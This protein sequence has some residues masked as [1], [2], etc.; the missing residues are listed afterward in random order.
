VP[1]GTHHRVQ[2]LLL[3]DAGG[4]LCL[5]CDG[6][7]EWRL[8][9]PASAR[10]LVG[11]RVTATGTRDDFNLLAVLSIEGQGPRREQFVA[12]W[13]FAAGVATS[14]LALAMASILLG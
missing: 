3:R 10:S 8:E 6:G 1:R 4:G 12:S 11:H 5:R 2:G 9:A 7:G 14:L 13:Q